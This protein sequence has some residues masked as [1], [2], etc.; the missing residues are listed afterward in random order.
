[1]DQEDGGADTRLDAREEIIRVQNRWPLSRCHY[2]Y[3]AAR[4]HWVSKDTN[5]TKTTIA[6]DS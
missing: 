6:G 5:N 1:M 2:W 3:Y 4:L